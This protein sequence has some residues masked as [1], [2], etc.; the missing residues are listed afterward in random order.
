MLDEAPLPLVDEPLV[1]D[2]VLVVPLVPVLLPER[3]A[4]VSA[5]VPV[6]ST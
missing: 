5:S 1:V 2:P 3:V 4:D 6:I